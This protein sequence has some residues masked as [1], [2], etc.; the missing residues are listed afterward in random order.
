METSNKIV[1]P[2]RNIWEAIP[3]IPSRIE[4]GKLQRA[5]SPRESHEIM[6]E[7]KD[8]ADTVQLLIDSNATRLEQLVPIRYGRMLA[9]SFAFLRGSALV[10]AQD[11]SKVPGSGVF[12]QCCGDCHL[13]NFGGY[14]TPERN[15]VFDIND[16]DETLPAPFEWDIKRL[17]AS[18]VVAG[19]YKQFTDRE[20]KKAAFA[21]VMSY[22]NK[23]REMS[24]MRQLEVWYNRIDEQA[25]IDLFIKDKTL[26][27]RVKT[28][29]EKAK[30]R[31]HEFVFPKISELKDG[32]R[33]ILDD[34]P[35][36]FHLADTTERIESG[37]GFFQEYFQSLSDDKKNVAGPLSA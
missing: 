3:S 14:A 27:K 7:K 37:A 35:L 12:V 26:V 28:I 6:P 34:P 25:I 17:A 15:Q 21:A 9:S 11:L 5:H 19:R 23:I 2:G 8:R 33:R 31:T 18:I 24:M 1:N 29:G 20:N 30:Q 16:F 10:M 4:N 13:M 36:I 22:A 32:K